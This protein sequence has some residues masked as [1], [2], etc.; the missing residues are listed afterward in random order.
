MSLPRSLLDQKG[1][2]RVRRTGLPRARLRDLYPFLIG[3][4]WW[5]F[6]G[7]MGLLFICINLAFGLLYWAAGNS[8][9]GATPGNFSDC[10]FFSVQTLA[11]IGYG[12][13]SPRGLAGHLIVAFEAY[14]GLFLFSVMSGL[15]FS[16]FSVPTAR[17]LF[18]RN[19]LI[20]SRNG[21][22]A[23][24]FRMANAR[25]NQIVEVKVG[26][27]VMLNEVTPEGEHL[28]RFIKLPLQTPES[29]I[30]ALSFQAVHLIDE[31]S[32]LSGFTAA[33]FSSRNLEFLTTFSGIDG[34][35]GQTVTGR[36]TY[37]WEM[38]KWNCRFKD[39]LESGT[40]G[41]PVLNLGNFHEVVA[42]PQ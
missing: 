20:G 25:G 11:T 29:P 28:R 15:A 17:V 1:N 16:K 6:F 26:L 40:D 19:L 14:C 10:F 5:Q 3:L 8:I 24:L 7:L 42:L 18:S 27:T 31:S 33:D 39:I 13:M 30:F 22:P 23:L 9:A 38:V 12:A 36:Y 21:I 41:T 34:T 2:L 37:P 4:R 35:L 32:P